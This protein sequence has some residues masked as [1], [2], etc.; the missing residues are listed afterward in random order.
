MKQSHTKTPYTF[1]AAMVL[2]C[3]VLISTHLTG[4]LYARYTTHGDGEDAARVAAFDVTID[5]HIPLSTTAAFTIQS[6]TNTKYTVTVTNKSETVVRAVLTA[7]NQ[8]NNLPINITI[9]PAEQIIGMGE[10]KTITMT[11]N[12]SS[13]PVS[14]TY[15]G[16]V[17]LILLT[18]TVEQVD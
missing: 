12:W 14:H 7:Q 10:N 17:D 13:T 8:T 2:L 18:L 5:D 6:I 9:S 1:Y 11:V 15:A 3:L 16:L 4:G